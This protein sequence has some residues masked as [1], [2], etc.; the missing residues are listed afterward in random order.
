MSETA[1]SQ[2]PVQVIDIGPLAL[3]VRSNDPSGVRYSLPTHLEEIRSPFYPL[4]REV[5]APSHCIDIGANY[6]FTGMLLRT[7]FPDASLTL[8]EPVHWLCEFIEH[9]FAHNDLALDRLVRAAASD[10]GDFETTFG[11]NPGGSQD[12]RVIPQGPNWQVITVPTVSLDQ[13]T[14]KIS[15]DEAVFIKIDTQGWDS[16]VLEGGAAFLQRHQRWVIKS[17][18]APW[19]MRSQ[20]VDPV[21]HLRQLNERYSVYE[22][23][24]RA[25]WGLKSLDVLKARPIGPEDAEAFTAYIESLAA[26][27]KGWGDV[28]IMPRE[29]Q[30]GATTSV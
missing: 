14:D 15:D 6:G 7:H 11:L 5:L 9:N 4:V 19:W 24:A 3:T 10:T 27:G 28:L 30:T 12:N 8:V 29:A 22:F 2:H 21:R 18:F 1:L 23:P 20:N 13:L 25:P 17:E 26:G 16:L